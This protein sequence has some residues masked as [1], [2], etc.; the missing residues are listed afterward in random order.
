MT[1]DIHGFKAGRTF[2]HSSIPTA[3]PRLRNIVLW[4]AQVFLALIFL[5]AGGSKLAGAGSMVQLFEE[6]GVGQW[7]RYL[8][9]AVEIGGALLL[10][11]LPSVTIGALLLAA[12]MAGAIMIHVLLV[13]GSAVPAT[14]LLVLTLTLAWFR[15]GP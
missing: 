11:A 10:L 8:T 1:R 9:G 6:I 5:M 3:R 13:G 15:R 4:V 7:F 14:I 2:M 12:T